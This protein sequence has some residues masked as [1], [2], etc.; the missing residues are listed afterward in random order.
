MVLISALSLELSK[1]HFL[2]KILIFS[3]SNE[4]TLFLLM[5]LL[6]VFLLGLK[7]LIEPQSSYW[8]HKFLLGT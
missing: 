4:R 6:G 8:A 7:V 5:F 2:T 1:V 3:F